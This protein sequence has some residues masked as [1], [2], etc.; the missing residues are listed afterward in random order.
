LGAKALLVSV[1]ELLYGLVGPVVVRVQVVGKTAV[2]DQVP[3]D[4]S[5]GVVGRLR[6]VVGLYFL[7]G[8]AQDTWPVLG[9]LEIFFPYDRGVGDA[10]GP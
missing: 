5:G 6:I 4:G 10:G 3:L 1:E 9:E 7:G 8:L 2:G